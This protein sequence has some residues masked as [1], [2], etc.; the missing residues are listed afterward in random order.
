VNRYFGSKEELFA[1]AVEV[2]FADNSFIEG[3]S[4]EFADRLTAAILTKKTGTHARPNDGFLLFL[5][6]APNHRAAEI[7][8]DS[9]ARRIE[10]PMKSLLQGRRAGERA[11]MI[12]ALMAG[13][14][15]MR[16][17][18]G[19]AALSDAN[20]EL[21]GELKMMFQQLIDGSAR[22]EPP[23]PQMHAKKHDK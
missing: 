1:A 23:R 9:I 14:L 22:G 18:I 20:G 17:V 11:A 15:L 6:S 4:T 8:R 2:A 21:S 16:R 7:M 19:N 13:F 3:E 12:I 10:G 5:R